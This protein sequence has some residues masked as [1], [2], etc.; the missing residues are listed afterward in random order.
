MILYRA[1]AFTHYAKVKQPCGHE[2]G[3]MVTD[4]PMYGEYSSYDEIPKYLKYRASLIIDNDSRRVYKD[5]ER[6]SWEE[7]NE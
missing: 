1:P 4:P 7:M 2:E 6:L 5:K 3:I